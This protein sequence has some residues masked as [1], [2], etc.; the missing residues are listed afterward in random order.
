M[1]TEILTIETNVP[2]PDSLQGRY[3][4]NKTSPYRDLAEKMNFGDCV[5]VNFKQ[6]RL[7]SGYLR[8]IEG[9]KAVQRKLENG[10]LRVWK[11][12]Q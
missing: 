10:M 11:L 1:A 12:K 5:T 4:K 2:V 8:K 9:A 6:A 7:L 3:F